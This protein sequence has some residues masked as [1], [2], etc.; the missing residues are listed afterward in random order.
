[1]HGIR[2][3]TSQ[4]M[5]GSLT[6]AGNYQPNYF[7]YQT[8]LTWELNRDKGTRTQDKRP[9]L[10]LNVITLLTIQNYL[11]FHLSSFILHPKAW[12]Q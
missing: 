5:L 1:M 8:M 9:R 12:S 6:T 3:K 10:T 11:V 4:Y 7:D 2:Y